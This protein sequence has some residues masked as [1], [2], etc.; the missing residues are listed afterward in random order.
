MT[1]LEI[2]LRTIYDEKAR[3]LLPENIKKN[4]EILGVTG[5]Y[6]GVTVSITG[7]NAE[8]QDTTLIFEE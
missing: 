2:T 1:E 7:N 6:E 5:T 8:V 3:K 4:I